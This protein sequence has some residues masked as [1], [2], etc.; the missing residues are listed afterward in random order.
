[1]GET[2]D[3]INACIE[4][5][6]CDEEGCFFY[7]EPDEDEFDYYDGD[8]DEYT[9]REEAV[10]ALFQDLPLAS[11]A[12]EVAY[13]FKRMTECGVATLWKHNFE[14]AVVNFATELGRV[15]EAIDPV[16]M[17][18]EETNAELDKQKTIARMLEMYAG[19]C[20][21]EK[22]EFKAEDAAEMIAGALKLRGDL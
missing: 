11:I 13:H 16:K 3:Y 7:G 6:E 1:M 8:D 4:N 14:R 21:I 12:F 10:S 2:A 17:R 22:R 5:G 19:R 15:V 9:N 20:A 18:E